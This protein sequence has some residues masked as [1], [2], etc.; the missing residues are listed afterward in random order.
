MF[1]GNFHKEVPS[2]RQL[3]SGANLFLMMKQTYGNHVKHDYH[4]RLDEEN[5]C[6]GSM[7]PT[8][9]FDQ[10]INKQ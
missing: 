2:P 8:E 7:F 9:Y 3:E 4:R 6:P 10:L 5:P 1:D